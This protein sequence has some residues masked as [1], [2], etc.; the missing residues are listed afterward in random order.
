V[1]YA[2]SN[3]KAEIGAKFF[4]EK[5]ADDLSFLFFR[6]LIHQI[7]LIKNKINNMWA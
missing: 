6:S 3:G 5:A 7:H 4:Y 2:S 1:L